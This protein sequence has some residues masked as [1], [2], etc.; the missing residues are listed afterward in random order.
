MALGSA[1]A[2]TYTVIDTGSISY[3]RPAVGG[4]VASARLDDDRR[5]EVAAAV[6][7]G[8]PCDIPVE[9]ALADASGQPTGSCSFVVALR[10]RRSAG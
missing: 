1:L 3:R 7:A 2:R 4:L 8:V 10:P 9:V 6:D 5:A